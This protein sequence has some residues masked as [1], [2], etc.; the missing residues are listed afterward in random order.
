MDI[1]T[2]LEELEDLPIGSVVLDE[3]GD[4]WQKRTWWRTDAYWALAGEDT[5]NLP[6]SIKHVGP[7]TLIY[8]P[9]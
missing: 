9:N 3:D 5:Y 7:W 6:E 2:R 8:R 1:L 4:A